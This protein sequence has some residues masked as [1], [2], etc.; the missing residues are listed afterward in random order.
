MFPAC[1][2]SGTVGWSCLGAPYLHLK[3]S[4]STVE[5]RRQI[6]AQVVPQVFSMA[7]GCPSH[8]TATHRHL[9]LAFIFSVPHRFSKTQHTPALTGGNANIPS[10][11]R[12]V[13]FPRHYEVVIAVR[14]ITNARCCSSSRFLVLFLFL[15]LFRRCR[16][17]LPMRARP[18]PIPTPSPSPMAGTTVGL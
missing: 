12:W 3:I 9:F 18:G 13:G 1:S 2:L 17:T 16:R 14:S 8:P 15:F 5:T 6:H 10:R 7:H 11:V 4:P